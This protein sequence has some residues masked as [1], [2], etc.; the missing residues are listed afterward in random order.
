MNAGAKK[1]KAEAE[2]EMRNKEPETGMH[3]HLQQTPASGP[4]V[5]VRQSGERERG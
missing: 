4:R 5:T 1:K 2:E 3:T